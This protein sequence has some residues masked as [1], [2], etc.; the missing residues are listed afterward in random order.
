MDARISG[1][2][3][4]QVRRVTERIADA[5]RRCGRAE[6]AVRLVAATKS[7]SVERIRE[8]IAAGLT[9]LGEN[10]LQEALPK[11]QALRGEPVQW[12]F[13]GAL[14]RRKVRDVVGRFELIH[15]VDTIDL[16]EEIDRRS[17]AA[18]I[19]QAVLLEV[20]LGGEKSK[21]GFCPDELELALPFLMNMVHIGVKGLMAIP[22]PASD[23][24]QTRPYFRA[25]RELAL[26]LSRQAN[27]S[28]TELSMGMSND[29]VVAVE[30]GATMVRVGTAIFGE[31]HV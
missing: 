14:Q 30:E 12:H 17:Q 19:T 8:G 7:V 15:S 1:S 25:L 20:N 18:G 13:I 4:A 22:P 27:A 16:A 21:S 31:R 11:I 10:R 2:V 6:D 5:A 3:G 29:Y 26:A 23:P 24:E 28:M 9:V